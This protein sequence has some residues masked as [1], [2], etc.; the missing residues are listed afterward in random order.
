MHAVSQE[1]HLFLCHT[2][3]GFKES[4]GSWIQTKQGSQIF[5]FNL[6]V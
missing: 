1:K 4:T 3:K 5:K 2:N 6:E